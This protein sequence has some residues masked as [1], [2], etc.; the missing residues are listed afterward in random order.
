ML[1]DKLHKIFRFNLIHFT[2]LNLPMV[3]AHISKLSDVSRIRI[4]SLYL[5]AGYLS[6]YLLTRL[7]EAASILIIFCQKREGQ[8]ATCGAVNRFAFLN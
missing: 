3:Q 4:W 7:E 8:Q 6:E 2:G 1:R 5:S